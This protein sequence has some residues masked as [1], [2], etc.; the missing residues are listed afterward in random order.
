M[1]CIACSRVLLS[2]GWKR[3]SLEVN[4]SLDIERTSLV[5]K[6]SSP[7]WPTLSHFVCANLLYLKRGDRTK[8][9][10]AHPILSCPT[11]PWMYI[12]IFY[13]HFSKNIS[14]SLLIFS[15]LPFSFYFVFIWLFIIIRVCL[16]CDE[17]L[18][19]FEFLVFFF[20]FCIIHE[21]YCII[22]LTFILFF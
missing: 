19:L 9:G 12:Y 16:G 18:S 5:W 8:T 17:M 2:W 11:Q 20:F 10:F 22:Q 14:H 21:F 6:L 15:R 4:Q 13:Y 7:I 3:L 1:H